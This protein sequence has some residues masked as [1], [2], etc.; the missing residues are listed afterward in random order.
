MMLNQHRDPAEKM[1]GPPRRSSAWD[2][3]TSGRVGI[4]AGDD[5]WNFAAAR[6]LSHVMIVFRR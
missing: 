4:P 5:R 2:D 1:A 6:N 3:A